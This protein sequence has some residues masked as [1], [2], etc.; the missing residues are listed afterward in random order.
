MERFTGN[1][2]LFLPTLLLV[3]AGC[4][5]ILAYPEVHAPEDGDADMDD[6]LD[7]ADM[8][9]DG[10]AADDGGQD[11]DAVDDEMQDVVDAD[12]VEIE[13][14]EPGGT[15]IL[16]F[17][18][19]L[20]DSAGAAVV[21]TPEGHIVVAATT[22]NGG[23]GGSDILVAEVDG[24]GTVLAAIAVGLT[25]DDAANDIVRISDGSFVVAGMTHYYIDSQQD[26]WILKLDADLT[27]VEWQRSLATGRNE[28][29]TAMTATAEG[30]FAVV[31][32]SDGGPIS[33]YVAM[34][35]S[36]GDPVWQGTIIG[37]HPML[38]DVVAFGVVEFGDL[39]LVPVRGG[40]DEP[41]PP[42]VFDAW[43][44]GLNK[45]TGSVD[46]VTGL[47]VGNNEDFARDVLV[48]PTGT[49]LLTGNSD[50]MAWFGELSEDGRDVL[51]CK[52]FGTETSGLRALPMRLFLT[53]SESNIA[54][55]G[56][57]V[58]DEEGLDQML[59]ATMTGVASPRGDW[60][61][62]FGRDLADRPGS[63]GF[64]ETDD[65]LVL[66][67]WS[68]DSD[69]LWQLV[70]IKMGNGGDV[71]DPCPME[72]GQTGFTLWDAYDTSIQDPMEVDFIF[73]NISDAF[74]TT[75]ASTRDM[76]GMETTILC[77][78]E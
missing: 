30:R 74:E 53:D 10:D 63:R 57:A 72:G 71:Q 9:I 22:M 1:I 59:L 16:S 33:A 61:A 51:Y 77:P 75:F 14:C 73:N 37:E 65:G 34:I 5:K 27:E 13:V 31:G 55:A 28:T 45:S 20:A 25:G 12:E 52:Q 41:P 43:I 40:T 8:E 68:Q 66:A 17:D 60:L 39:V 7:A 24:C 32:T 47:D 15:W 21:A 58:D 35:A 26:T 42:E 56:T 11:L 18:T 64:A 50:G 76:T 29:I 69:N 78:A 46:L 62:L 38:F 23:I 48:T 70:L 3:F 36:N 4:S 67:G 6:G 49:I 19:D 54:I 44:L 2:L